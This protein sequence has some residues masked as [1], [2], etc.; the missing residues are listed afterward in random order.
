M[1]NLKL[2]I[3]LETC[4]ELREDD[5]YCRTQGASFEMVSNTLHE[6]G[7]RL[8]QLSDDT[9]FLRGKPYLEYIENK[10]IKIE[11]LKKRRLQESKKW[12]I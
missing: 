12:K 6:A 4:A 11:K 2:K 8:K 5:G 7:D 3:Y 9:M 1:V 10:K